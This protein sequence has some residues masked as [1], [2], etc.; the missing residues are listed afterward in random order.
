MIKLPD[1]R[2]SFEYENNFYLS[3]DPSRISKIISHYELFK[4]SLNVPG[5]IV[6]CGVFKGASLTRFSMFRN[7]L[8]NFSAKKIIG[9]DTFGKFPPTRYKDDQKFRSNFINSSGQEG[10]TENQLLQVLQHKGTDK[11]VEL[12]K[13]NIIKTVPKY[14]KEHPELKISFLNID[15][16]VYEPALIILRHLYPRVSR[17]GVILIDDYGVFPGETK[18]I[19][20]FFKDKKI[21]IQK[22][23]YS[24]TPCYI[25]KD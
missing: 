6:E 8:S 9:F 17:G 16:D 10:I 24:M 5:A 19:D 14:V 12:I 21:R 23:P 13:G 1:V 18:A 4:M 2:R 22:L 20:K 7:L 3:C 11:N 25:I 15:T